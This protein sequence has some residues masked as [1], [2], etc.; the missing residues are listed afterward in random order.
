MENKKKQK[1]LVVRLSNTQK[2]KLLNLADNEG[3]KT[4]S[5]YIRDKTLNNTEI[6][7]HHKLNRILDEIKELRNGWIL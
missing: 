3:Y 2:E 6:E 5:G 1:S 4:I 7:L